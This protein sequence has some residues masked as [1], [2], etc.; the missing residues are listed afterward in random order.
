MDKQYL[1]LLYES[2]AQ[3]D[4]KL[5]ELA[6]I[7]VFEGC[8]CNRPASVRLRDQEMELRKEQIQMIDQFISN[9]LSA[10]KQGH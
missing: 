7:K 4:H 10:N 6:K 2:K 9:Y 3:I 8:R 5:D 1:D